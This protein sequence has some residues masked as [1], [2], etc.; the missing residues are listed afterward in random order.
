[1]CLSPYHAGYTR[2]KNYEPAEIQGEP[3]SLP[4]AV[5][6]RL[7]RSNEPDGAYRPAIELPGALRFHSE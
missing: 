6:G 5:Q 2:G 4:C 3:G 1:M 7:C